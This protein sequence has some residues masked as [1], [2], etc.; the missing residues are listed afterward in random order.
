[1]NTR[2]LRQTSP[3][4]WLIVPRLIAALPLAGFG[5]FHLTGMTPLM[6]ILEGAGIP[7]PQVN[8][9][10]APVFMVVA[11]LSM[12]LGFYARA[13]AVIGSSAMLV[14]TYSKLVIDQWPGPMEPPLALPLVVLAACLM[15]LVKGA[16]NWSLDRK[17]VA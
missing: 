4:K 12:G 8:Y 11:G 15:I 7:F 9:F 16:G 1:M 17:A 3:D 14:A 6:Q 2:F 13:G 10:L 5:S